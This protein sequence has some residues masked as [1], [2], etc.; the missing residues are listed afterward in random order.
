MASEEVKEEI[1]RLFCTAEVKNIHEEPTP[2]LLAASMYRVKPYG[3]GRFSSILH[4]IR[5]LLSH[6]VSQIY[7]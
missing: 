4:L 6:K 1:E 3:H 5:F 7:L 2:V